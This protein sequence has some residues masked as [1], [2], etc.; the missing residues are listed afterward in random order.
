MR[1]DVTR[2]VVSDLWTLCRTGDASADTRALVDAFL[3]EDPGLAES[4]KKEEET[5]ST[6]V[7]Q[8][9]LSPDAER[10]MLDDAAKSA[11]LKLLIVGG[12]VALGAALLFAAFAGVL[13][14]TFRYGW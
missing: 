8:V 3:A 10:R 12:S 1:P 6:I 9:R 14:L 4:L 5:M 13:I 2:D 11:R 7:P